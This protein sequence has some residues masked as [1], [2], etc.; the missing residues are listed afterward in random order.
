MNEVEA[1]KREG[2]GQENRIEGGGKGKSQ[3]GLA[4]K[5]EW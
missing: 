1:R 2:I 4:G 3:V 5:L